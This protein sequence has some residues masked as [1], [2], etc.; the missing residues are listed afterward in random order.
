MYGERVQLVG[1]SLNQILEQHQ[2]VVG[3]VWVGL[4]LVTVRQNV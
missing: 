2:E 1:V 3:Q 4:D